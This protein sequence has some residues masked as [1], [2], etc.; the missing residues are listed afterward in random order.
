MGD[1]FTIG[2]GAISPSELDADINDALDKTERLDADDP[3]TKVVPDTGGDVQ[4][5]EDGLLAADADA[6]FMDIPMIADDPTGTP[7][8][9][10]GHAAL[11]FNKTSKKLWLYVPGIG[12]FLSA[13]FSAAP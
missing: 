4:I 1:P 13:A 3:T 12:W 5:G 2:A 8:L 7:T 10:A 9:D 6:G 11:A